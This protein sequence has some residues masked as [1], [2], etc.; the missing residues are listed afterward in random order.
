M[1]WKGGGGRMGVR[2]LELQIVVSA[3]CAEVVV[4]G[5]VVGVENRPERVGTVRLPVG[6]MPAV[7]PAVAA[8][9]P[10]TSAAAPTTPT[11]FLALVDAFAAPMWAWNLSD[12]C[13]FFW[14]SVSVSSGMAEMVDILLN[15]LQRDW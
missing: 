9:T 7:T 14:I 11:I 12:A 1:V 13:G 10:S 3:V 2:S 6:A 15:L 8:S 5:V 4:H